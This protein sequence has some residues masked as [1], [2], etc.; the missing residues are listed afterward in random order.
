MQV[1]GL[2]GLDLDTWV[3]GS[4]VLSRILLGL[5][6]AHCITLITYPPLALPLLLAGPLELGFVDLTRCSGWHMACDV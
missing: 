2:V 3:T 5:V 4:V 1:G 6:S